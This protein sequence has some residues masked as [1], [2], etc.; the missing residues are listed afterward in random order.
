MVY[1]ALEARQVVRE[2]TLTSEGYWRHIVQVLPAVL[3]KSKDVF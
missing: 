1:S 3:P 2:D